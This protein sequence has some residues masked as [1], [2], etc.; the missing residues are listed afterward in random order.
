MDNCN[1]VLIFAALVVGGVVL[2][3]TMKKRGEPYK[4][5]FMAKGVPNDEFISRPH[6]EAQ[7]APRLDPFRNGQY[8]KLNGYLPNVDMQATPVN[9]LGNGSFPIMADKVDYAQMGTSDEIAVANADCAMAKLKKYDGMAQ[10]SAGNGQGTSEKFSMNFSGSNGELR[11]SSPM[12]NQALEYLSPKDLLPQADMASVLSKDPSDPN[13]YMFDRT[14]FSPL[15]RRNLN[16]VDFIRG[17]LPIKQ[18]K[19]GWFDSSANPGTDLM[20]G[21]VQSGIIG[22]SMEERTEMQDLVYTRYD[23]EYPLQSEVVSGD[24]ENRF[25]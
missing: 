1:K 20:V 7:L 15:K 5:I 21:S 10:N 4:D 25:I 9:P 14:L 12:N 2:Y 24:L 11:K 3:K 18:Q 17:D 16:N 19:N 23:H 6:F 22:P 8:D 13:V